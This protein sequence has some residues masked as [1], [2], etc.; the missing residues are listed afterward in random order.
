MTVN[1]FW[2]ETDAIVICL[3]MQ[4]KKFATKIEYS[5]CYDNEN[6]MD[7]QLHNVN[8]YLVHDLQTATEKKNPFHSVVTLEMPYPVDK[9]ARIRILV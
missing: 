9:H 6:A 5:F 1:L 3:E 2:E 7:L 8:I 4:L